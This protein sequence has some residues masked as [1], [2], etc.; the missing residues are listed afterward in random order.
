M[1]GMTDAELFGGLKP[2]PLP[3]AIPHTPG[4]SAEGDPAI[5][6]VLGEAGTDPEGMKAVA[7]TI[8]NRA[9]AQGVGSYEVVTDPSNGYEAWQDADARARTMKA[10]PVGSEGYEAAR[11]AVQGIL[12][13]S[14]APPY[15]YDHFYSPK[16]QAALGR[17]VPDWAQGEGTDVGGNRFYTLGDQTRATAMSDADNAEW[18]KLYGS[19]DVK[20]TPTGG[21]PNPGPLTKQQADTAK[22]LA[23]HG[24]MDQNAPEGSSTRP[25]AETRTSG[26]PDKP[27]TWY[28]P[29]GGGLRQVGSDQDYLPQYQALVDTQREEMAKP[30]FGRVM[31]G[32]QQGV[33]D[34]VGSVNKLTGGGMAVPSSADF[35]GVPLPSPGGIDLAQGS[36][37]A[38]DEQRNRFNLIH[39]PD[40]A[41]QG[42]RVVG[43]M[44]ALAPA[45]AVAEAPVAA[46][47][48]AIGRAA[49]ALAPAIDVLGSGAQTAN[50]IMRAA[51]LAPRG[52]VRGAEAGGLL[53]QTS[54]QPVGSQIAQ[55]ALTGAIAEPA[56]AV[57]P[58][59]AA[60][61]VNKLMGI[62]E[63][64]SPAVRDLANLAV[65]DYGI[66]LRVSQIKGAYSR[67]MAVADS[68]RISQAGTGYAANNAEQQAAF[69]RAVAKT[70]GEDADALSPDVM[71]RAKQRI[72]SEFDRVAAN[73]TIRD[74]NAL[75]ANLQ[76]VLQEAGQV[77]PEGSLSPLQ[78][79]IEN[80]VSTFKDGAMSGESYQA[81]TRRGSP[82]DRATQSADPNIR[83]YA[84]QIRSVLDDALETAAPEEDL[85]ALRNARMQY[86]NLM[87]VKNLAAKAGVEGTISPSLLNGAVNRSFKNRAF[88]GAGDL[89]ELADIGQ[90][91]MKE[92]PNSGTAPRIMDALKRS[93]VPAGL[94][95]GVGGYTLLHDPGMA[96]QLAG[97]GAALG[98]VGVARN[99]LTGAYNRSPL[100]RNMLLN[101]GPQFSPEALAAMARIGE[102]ARG[103]GVPLAVDL[104][105]R[106]TA[107]AY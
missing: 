105:N 12:E 45:M 90:T 99:M 79:Q 37:A 78:K 34:V 47:G 23:L 24:F 57:A 71:S 103:G 67:P 29:R 25:L 93:A 88:Q 76:G 83:H 43:N 35:G 9:K 49:P 82:L 26:A 38:F 10:F 56:I 69:T 81:L 6:T 30:F 58:Q 86:K 27:G 32:A 8:A 89:G 15:T 55:G 52:A 61:A 94:A 19:R 101:E 41:A 33:G 107:P 48:G 87:T 77:L 96:L 20:I 11:K 31:T 2:Q 21:T 18:E 63:R 22:F 72:G 42:G 80:I 97:T 14:V 3:K 106:L 102:A 95:G 66:P 50:P 75:Q 59:T 73:T 74:T 100:V 70:F 36:Q 98:G 91:F 64:P 84:Q 62:G 68:E 13:G 44:A 60:G 53:S 46:L 16:A 4:G 85:A 7:S 54:D 65:N 1:S 39:G 104:R 28:M 17:D 5:W 51:S 92:P 40:I